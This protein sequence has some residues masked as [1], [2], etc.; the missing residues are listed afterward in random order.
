MIALL[1]K[2]WPSATE[3]QIDG[4]LVMVE[5]RVSA[6]ARNYR[7]SLPHVGGPVLTVPRSGNWKE[8]SDFFNRQ[9]DWLGARLRQAAKPVTFRAGVRIPLRGVDHRIVATGGV[10]G[11]VA[12]TEQDGEFV[13]SVPG[14]PAHRARRL[15]DWLRRRRWRICRSAARSTAGGWALNTSRFPCAASR[16][17]GARAPLPGD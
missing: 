1:Q 15:T 8:A 6:R 11:R 9:L 13:L 7:L 14:E 16:R 3:A 4:K 5:V 2:K 12:A 17:A 10:R